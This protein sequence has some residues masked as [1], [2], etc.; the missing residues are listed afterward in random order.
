MTGY[1]LARS[2]TFDSSPVVHIRSTKYRSYVLHCDQHIIAVVC[3]Y[4]PFVPLSLLP[5]VLHYL[6]VGRHL[7]LEV[8]L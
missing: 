8:T 4:Q 6:F 3:N 2:S 5:A 7:L 1:I